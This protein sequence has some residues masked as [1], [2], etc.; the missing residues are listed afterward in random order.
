MVAAD[1][2]G[3]CCPSLFDGPWHQISTLQDADLSGTF[4]LRQRILD[5]DVLDRSLQLG[6]VPMGVRHIPAR[7]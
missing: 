2:V 1:H 6:K 7:H 5:V 4:F 3:E